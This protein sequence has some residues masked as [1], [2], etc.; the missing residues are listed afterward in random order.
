VKGLLNNDRP[1]DAAFTGTVQ[2]GDPLA[3]AFRSRSSMDEARDAGGKV[4]DQTVRAA[5]QRASQLD[6]YWVRIKTNC[7]VRT[8]P[9]YDREWF[10]L[11]DGRTELTTPDPSC[12]GAVRD[13]NQLSTGVRRVMADAQEAARHAAV[14]PGQLRDIRHRYRMD[15]PGFDR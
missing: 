2:G 14:L 8:A 5:A 15:W 11:W 6:D 7:A 10:G 12:V 9:G 13:L 4:Y 1:P 3:P